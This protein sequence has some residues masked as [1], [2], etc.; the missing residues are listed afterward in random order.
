MRSPE[1]LAEGREKE[2]PVADEPSVDPMSVPTS[3]WST[4][5]PYAGSEVVTPALVISHLLPSP[6]P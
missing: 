6:K 5:R 4:P 1:P 3:A 2:A